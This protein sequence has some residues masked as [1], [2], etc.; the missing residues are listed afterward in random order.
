MAAAATDATNIELDRTVVK[1]EPQL[2]P[3]PTIGTIEQNLPQP[4]LNVCFG[5]SGRSGGLRGQCPL[6]R[7]LRHNRRLG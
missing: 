7:E 1:L 6:V 3:D 2:G 5:L 4:F